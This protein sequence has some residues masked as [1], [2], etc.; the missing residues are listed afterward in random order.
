M[1]KQINKVNFSK[2]VLESIN[3]VS[4]INFGRQND[5]FEKTKLLNKAFTDLKN[6]VEKKDKKI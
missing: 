4:L 2:R 5:S 1:K 3:N 6:T